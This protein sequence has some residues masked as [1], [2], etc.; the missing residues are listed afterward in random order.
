[1]VAYVSS[2]SSGNKGNNV[3]VNPAAFQDPFWGVLNAPLSTPT[4]NGVEL[5]PNTADIRSPAA[6]MLT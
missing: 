2:C 4:T 3:G 6:I 1:M 5:F